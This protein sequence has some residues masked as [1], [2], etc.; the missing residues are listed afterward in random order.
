M[1]KKMAEAQIKATEGMPVHK[2]YPEGYRWIELGPG[3]ELPEGWTTKNGAYYDP[4]GERHVHPDSEKVANALKYEGDTM[5]HCVGGYCPDV[6]EGRSRIYSLRDAKGEPHVTVETRPGEITPFDLPKDLYEEYRSHMAEGISAH[7]GRPGAT[8]WLKH[9][10][11]DVAKQIIPPEGIVQIKGKQNR[12]PNEEYLPYVQD[13]VKGGEWSDVGDFKNTGFSF[14]ATGPNGI[15]DANQL[16]ML[17]GAG[18]KVPKYLTREEANK[19]ADDLY[20]VET[21]KDPETG[22]PLKPPGMKRGGEVKMDKGGDPSKKKAIDDFWAGMKEAVPPASNLGPLDTLKQNLTAAYEGAKKIPGNLYNLATD[23]VGYVKNLP[24]PTGEQIVNAFSPAD[25]GF[26]GSYRPHTPLKPDPDVGTRYKVQDMGG[27]APRKD[28]DFETLKD[29]S[30]NIF[31]WDAT[32]RNKLVTEVSDVPLTKPVLTEGGDEY[33][34][35]LNHI[36]NRIAGASN[37]GI[38]NRIK[39]RIDQASWENQALGGS[40]RVIGFPSRMGGGA[41]FFSTF[42]ADIA[43]DLLMQGGLNKKELAAL[44]KDLR[45]MKFDGK[46]AP[47]A[48]AA[49]VGTKDFEAQLRA[50]IEAGKKTPAA[51][52][53]NLRKAFMNRMSM[54]GNQKRLGFNIE[55]LQGSVL[56]DELKG[57]PKGYIGNVAAELDVGAPLRPSKSSSYSTDFSGQYLASMPNMPLEFALPNTY[58]LIYGEMKKKYPK[59]D[60]NALRNMTIGAMEKRKSGIS[61]IVTPRSIDAVKTYQEGLKKGEFDPNNLQEVYDYMRRKKLQLKLK[62]GGAVQTKSGLLKVK[63]KK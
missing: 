35:D 20:R 56:S 24:A 2:E 54:V 36:K 22:L 46:D 26:M 19:Y 23:P 48:G 33:M 45:S 21:G 12:A 37:E 8:E 47:F 31:P 57:V 34:L 63:R 27:L 17:E 51:T 53:G 58:E 18:I 3:K 52:P 59:A 4:Q 62:G 25:M 42:P 7:G 5:G 32:S 14:H 40:G 6:L 43:M 28:L 39:D 9:F 49:P 50:G 15:F 60:E 16:K 41:E 55:D 29:A 38:A 11:P 44:T 30:V 10:H 1:A 13:F 61:E